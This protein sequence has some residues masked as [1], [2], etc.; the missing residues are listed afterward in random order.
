MLITNIIY[1]V[2][3]LESPIVDVSM[4]RPNTL[5]ASS[6][7]ACRFLDSASDEVP[8]SVNVET[9]STS[10]PTLPSAAAI[11]TALGSRQN[12]SEIRG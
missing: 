1:I 9:V 7:S 12:S 8:T 11:T 4:R 6:C 5:Y 2:A 3:T 10:H